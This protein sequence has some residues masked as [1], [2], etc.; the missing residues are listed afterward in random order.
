M[1]TLHRPQ[2]ES[3]NMYYHSQVQAQ[4][5]V[6]QLIARDNTNDKR[7][8]DSDKRVHQMSQKIRQQEQAILSYEVLCIYVDF[9]HANSLCLL[10]RKRILICC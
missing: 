7:I 5:E 3:K 1:L 4:V 6:N 8:I 2:W 9:F 10:H